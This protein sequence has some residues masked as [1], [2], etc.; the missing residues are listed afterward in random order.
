MVTHCR[1]VIKGVTVSTDGI[2]NLFSLNKYVTEY[3]WILHGSK[4]AL[5][6]KKDDRELKFKVKIKTKK[7]VL[8]C[9]NLKRF[10]EEEITAMKPNTQ[11]EFNIG[12]R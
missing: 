10:S 6:L 5:I 9:I 4:E 7:G 3:G 8:F 1:I 2:Y 12:E 11:N